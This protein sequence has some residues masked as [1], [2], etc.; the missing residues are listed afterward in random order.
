MY[1]QGYPRQSR[2]YTTTFMIF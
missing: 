1:H 2:V